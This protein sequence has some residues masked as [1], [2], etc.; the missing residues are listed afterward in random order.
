MNPDIVKLVELGRQNGQRRYD[1]MRPAEARAAFAAGWDSLQADALDIESVRDAIICVEDRSITLRVYRGK[2]TCPDVRLPCLLFLHGG[3]WV[4][5]N[6]DSHDRL[7]RSLSS[8]AGVA[9]IAVDYRL[10]PENPFPAGLDDAAEALRWIAANA[11]KLAI[12]EDMLAVGGDSAGGNLAAVLAIMSRDGLVPPLVF[13]ALIYPAVDLTAR[14]LSYR[15]IGDGV[16]LTSAT[17]RWFIENYVPNETDR[18]DWRASPLLAPSLAG[19]APALIV[20]MGY[21]PLRDEGRDYAA[22]LEA[23][24]V[25]VM[26]LHMSD[27][28]HGTLLQGR[29]VHAGK[30]LLSVIGA[31]VKDALHPLLV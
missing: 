20:T 27:L 23:E 6:L 19:L 9:V 7:C 8:L 5:G 29:V 25:P 18:T 10:S 13:Q 17:M 21:D 12:R 1:E 4:V 15:S 31:I 26:A 28:A 2:G 24:G 3:G 30:S 16:P 22:R 11:E 14:S